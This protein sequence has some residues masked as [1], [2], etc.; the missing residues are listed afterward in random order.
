MQS[1]LRLVTYGYDNGI[2]FTVEYCYSTFHFVIRNER[3]NRVLDRMFRSEAGA[4][5]YCASIYSEI[6]TIKSLGTL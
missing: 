5:A 1:N 6:E 3:T 2:E 4:C